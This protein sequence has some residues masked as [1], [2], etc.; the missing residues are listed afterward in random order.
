MDQYKSKQRIKRGKEIGKKKRESGKRGME[1]LYKGRIGVLLQWVGEVATYRWVQKES[2]SPHTH[3]N[4]NHLSFFG[5][6]ILAKFGDDRLDGADK[7]IRKAQEE[8]CYQCHR[9]GGC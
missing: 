2:I 9:E 3:D 5:W 1:D 6:V 4:G 8:S 7:T